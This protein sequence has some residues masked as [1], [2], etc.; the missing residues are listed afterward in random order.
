MRLFIHSN[1][2]KFCFQVYPNLNILQSGGIFL[3]R[4]LIHLITWNDREFRESNQEKLNKN[5][6]HTLY[7]VEICQVSRIKK[8]RKLN[9]SCKFCYG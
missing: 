8:R 7:T 3:S 2:C 6:F 1:F 4:I 5:L 9:F